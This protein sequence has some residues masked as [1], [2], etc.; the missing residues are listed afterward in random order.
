MPMKLSK[1]IKEVPKVKDTADPV[2]I[3]EIADRLGVERHTVDQW[4]FRGYLPERDYTVGG[5]PAW[6]WASIYDWAVETERLR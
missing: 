1:S 5:G 2:G 3:P 6:E 4:G